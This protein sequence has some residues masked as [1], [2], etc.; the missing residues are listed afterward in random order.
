MS[1]TA[2]AIRRQ[3]PAA[4]SRRFAFR[5][6]TSSKYVAKTDG[7]CRCAI[8]S[9][10]NGASSLS[11]ILSVDAVRSK[12]CA[13]LDASLAPHPAVEIKDNAFALRKKGLPGWGLRTRNQRSLNG[14]WS[15]FRHMSLQFP[16]GH[17]NG[18]FNES[19]LETCGL[20][21]APAGQIS[22]RSMGTNFLGERRQEAAP[23]EVSRACRRGG[24]GRICVTI[25]IG[26]ENPNGGNTG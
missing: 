26:G 9:T 1:L 14:S 13:R 24:V 3:R 6:K 20:S 5:A 10:T 7:V 18:F 16:L 21:S 15:Q 19:Q 2:A 25:S 22:Q 11:S 12:I 17:V 23:F 8:I 4:S